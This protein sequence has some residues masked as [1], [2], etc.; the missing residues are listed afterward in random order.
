[1]QILVRSL[2]IWELDGLE[3]L[4]WPG[5]SITT[6]SDST[7]SCRSLSYVAHRNF[8][9]VRPWMRRSFTRLT[10]GTTNDVAV[11]FL[12]VLVR[13][14]GCERGYVLSDATG[15]A[16]IIICPSI[17]CLVC[18]G[19]AFSHFLG[20]EAGSGPADKV[21]SKGRMS[22]KSSFD[23]CKCRQGKGQQISTGEVR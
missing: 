1:M 10:T 17:Q 5:S 2:V 11:S 13:S 19:G 18:C 4:L 8:Q 7:A 3:V 16:F 22:T 14:E 12:S 9:M 15:Y 6:S 23:S 20:G 21:L